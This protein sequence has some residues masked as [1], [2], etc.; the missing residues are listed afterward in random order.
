MDTAT[1]ST[2]GQVVIP[3]KVREALRAGA[4]SRLGFRIEGDRVVVCVIGKA[5]T[6]YADEGYGLLRGK[7]KP[8]ALGRWR[9]VLKTAARKRHRAGR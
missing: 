6:G 2:K 1:M 5:K 7:G 8:V 3:K 4:G 9:A